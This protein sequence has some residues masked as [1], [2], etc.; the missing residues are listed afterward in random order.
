MLPTLLKLIDFIRGEVMLM[1]QK[2][3]YDIVSRDICCNNYDI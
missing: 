1:L 2:A 3:L